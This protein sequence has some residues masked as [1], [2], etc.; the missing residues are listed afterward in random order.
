[1]K[2]T[3]KLNLPQAIV[4]AVTNDPYDKGDADFSVTGLI[5]PVRAKVLTARNDAILTEDV[6]KRLFSLYGQIGHGILER[7]DYQAVPERFFIK[8]TV[9]GKEY[10]IS[11]KGDSLLLEN[12]ALD[13]YKLCRVWA[14][15]DGPKDDWIAQLNLYRLGLF[16]AEGFLIE[17]LRIT[18]LIQDWMWRQAGRGKYPADPVVVL[19]IPVWSM[20]DTNA[21]LME[22]LHAHVIGALTPDDDLP[23]C[24]DAERYVGKIEWAVMKPGRKSALK[25]TKIKAEAEMMIEENAGYFLEKRGGESV[26]CMK[27]C[28]VGQAGLC[29]QWLGMIDAGEGKMIEETVD[30]SALE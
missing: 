27:Y 11:G 3:N 26:R 24:T 21:Y 19:D 25:L 7:A 28:T 15:L 29:S 9:N 17:K 8:R 5:A 16:E 13:D 23:Y 4:N 10:A 12:K 22:R 6:S 14:V 1:M 2:F 18:G 20:E 30:A